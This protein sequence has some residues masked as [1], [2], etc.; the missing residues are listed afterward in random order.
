MWVVSDENF[1]AGKRLLFDSS[2][3]VANIP[4]VVADTVQAVGRRDTH[5]Y[6]YD[7]SFPATLCLVTSEHLTFLTAR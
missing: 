5:G 7:G 3:T 4:F 2:S 6:S 1:N